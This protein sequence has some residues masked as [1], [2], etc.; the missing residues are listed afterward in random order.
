MLTCRPP[1]LG[2]VTQLE[3]LIG[4]GAVCAGQYYLCAGLLYRDGY[5]VTVWCGVVWSPTKGVVAHG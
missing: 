2:P 4:V 1:G 3:G 5:V